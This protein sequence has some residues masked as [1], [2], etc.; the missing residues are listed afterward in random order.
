MK[1]IKRLELRAYRER[2]AESKEP[3]NA[4]FSQP[5]EVAAVVRSIFH[6]VD[7]ESFLAIPVD[8]KNKVL[9]Y[10][11]AARGGVDQCQVAA[12][13]VFR[14]AVFMGATSVILAHN[15]PSGDPA[16]SVDDKFLTDRLCEAG[17]LLGIPVLDHLIVSEKG[18]YS[19][20]EQGLIK[21]DDLAGL[22]LKQKKAKP[23]KAF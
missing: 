13:E 10:V 23:R 3:Y 1:T 18:Y 5:H 4:C 11:E 2:L 16:P 6:G 19:F 17:K 21:T 14:A 20:A 22:L 8:I 12:R 9:G 15:H 7:H